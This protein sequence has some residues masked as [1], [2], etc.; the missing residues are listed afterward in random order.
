MTNKDA[1]MDIKTTKAAKTILEQAAFVLG[2][3]LSAFILDCAIPRAR[4]ILAQSETI[5]LNQE[6][7]ERFLAALEDSPKAN[8]KLKQL[9][10]K[11]SD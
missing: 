6:E 7:S 8:L 2:T 11:Y 1:R 3:T 9:F 5:R 10:E 4:E